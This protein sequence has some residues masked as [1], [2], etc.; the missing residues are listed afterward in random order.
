MSANWMAIR[1]PAVARVDRI[2]GYIG[3][4]LTVICQFRPDEAAGDHWSVRV[5]DA[6]GEAMRLKPLNGP[7]ASVE[8][9]VAW[10]RGYGCDEVDVVATINLPE[11]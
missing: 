6:N 2:L 11:K 1:A 10:V 3:H 9:A 4:M 7:Q 5:F 8:F